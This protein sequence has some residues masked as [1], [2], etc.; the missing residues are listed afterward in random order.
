MILKELEDKVKEFADYVVQQSRSNLTKGGKKGSYNASGKLYNSIKP[1]IIT[2]KDA[3]IVQFEMEDYG[4]FQDQGVKG[5]TSSYIENA[6]SPF[7]FGTG[8]GRK[9][10]LTSGIQNWVKFKKFRWR[11]KKGRYMSYN[12]ISYI[13]INSIWRKGL[14]ARF[15]FTTPFDR[16]IQRFGDQFLNAFLIDTEKNIIFGEKK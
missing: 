4:L 3:F 1:S 16:G 9:G 14:K 15:F 13:I 12:S 10:G 8:S 5:T 11:D 2:E 6:K 7:K